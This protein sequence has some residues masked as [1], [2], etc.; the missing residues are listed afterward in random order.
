MS[1]L[2]SGHISDAL[3]KLNKM[4]YQIAPQKRPPQ[5]FIAEGFAL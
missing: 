5:Y 1:L 3:R 2:L 4:Y